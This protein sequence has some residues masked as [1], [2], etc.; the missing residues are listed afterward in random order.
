MK[1]GGNKGR[2]HRNAGWNWPEF[3]FKYLL[4][5]GAFLRHASWPIWRKVFIERSSN[6]IFEVCFGGRFG[7]CFSGAPR[8]VQGLLYYGACM[9]AHTQSRCSLRCFALQTEEPHFDCRRSPISTQMRV[10][11]EGLLNCRSRRVARVFRHRSSRYPIF[12]S[13]WDMGRKEL[14]GWQTLCAAL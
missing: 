14:G 7:R 10:K 9:R 12:I 11:A 5:C 6:A 3:G 13:S 2:M 1:P 8:A 4:Q